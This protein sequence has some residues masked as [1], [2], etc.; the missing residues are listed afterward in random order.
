MDLLELL[1]RGSTPLPQVLHIL[2]EVADGL[3]YAHSKGVVHRDIK[4][5]NI[6]VDR[7][8]RAKVAD[9]R[10][11]IPISESLRMT[12][13]GQKSPYTPHYAAPEQEEGGGTG[14]GRSDVYDMGVVLYEALTGRLP[15]GDWALS[16]KHPVPCLL[17]HFARDR[18]EA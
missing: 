8:G 12:L 2:L 5:S 1:A 14:D 18:R 7:D 16:A 9:F 17:S 13:L 6:L 15:V 3:G 4:P 10:L 11:A